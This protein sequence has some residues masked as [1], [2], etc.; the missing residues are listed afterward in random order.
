MYITKPMSMDE[1]LQLLKGIQKQ[2]YLEG[3]DKGSFLKQCQDSR[4]QNAKKK[5][6]RRKFFALMDVMND[7]IQI[8]IR[9]HKRAKYKGRYKY[10]KKRGNSISTKSPKLV[11]MT[12][13][14]FIRHMET[15]PAWLKNN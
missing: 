15:L 5:V 9:R 4:L 12:P 8:G 1:R 11:R 7:H 13:E 3:I 6:L 14:E 2:A 10:P